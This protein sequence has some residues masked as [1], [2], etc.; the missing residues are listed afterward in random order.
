MPPR[1]PPQASTEPPDAAALSNQ[2]RTILTSN[3]YKSLGDTMA[4]ALVL[5][6]IPDELEVHILDNAAVISI[7]DEQRRDPAPVTLPAGTASSSFNRDRFIRGRNAV[8]G[9]IARI[10][11]IARWL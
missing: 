3:G 8:A 11:I 2:Y 4:D 6:G 7:T 10:Q 5:P 1:W 9:A